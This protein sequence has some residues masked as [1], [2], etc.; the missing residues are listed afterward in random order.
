[1]KGQ[2]IRFHIILAV[3]YG[4]RWGWSTLVGFSSLFANPQYPGGNGLVF[5]LCGTIA[6]ALIASS[7]DRFSRFRKAASLASPTLCLFGTALVVYSGNTGTA[8]SS[9]ILLVGVG[10][11]GLGHG[12]SEPLWMR[13]FA[14]MQDSLH[15]VTTIAAGLVIGNLVAVLFP[16]LPIA[17]VHWLAVLLPLAFFPGLL[18][19]SPAY[20]AAAK[21]PQQIRRT[22]VAQAMV[23]AA[24]PSILKAFTFD[25]LWG[26]ASPTSTIPFGINAYGVVASGLLLALLLATLFS[27]RMKSTA[28]RH[29]VSIMLLVAMFLA[30]T[31]FKGMASGNPAWTT[32]ER[33]ADTFCFTLFCAILAE[34]MRGSDDA[35]MIRMSS[36]S[37][38]VQW[39]TCLLCGLLPVG[40]SEI[41]NI[42]LLATAY[43]LM[44][45]V[46]FFPN[47]SRFRHS[48]E[49]EGAPVQSPLEKACSRIA[50]EYGL[51]AREQQVL[52]LLAQG[53]SLPFV[54]NELYIAETTAKGH[55]RSIYRKLNVHT[56]QELISLVSEA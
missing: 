33:T 37:F 23:L 34:A 22:L 26:G 3:S 12:G 2:K 45:V 6:L 4:V 8:H 15:M 41:V 13:R 52:V 48:S 50:Y 7:P 14:T 18:V 40:S 11:M 27:S 54:A 46:A 21:P 32:V 28:L 56:R 55:T 42:L 38:G 24:A 17:A 1:M 39:L 53:R 20:R 25:G 49:P 44:I 31:Y 43:L 5:F 47:A 36:I 51:S 16:L 9:A 35:S 30:L 29:R 19:K 10:I